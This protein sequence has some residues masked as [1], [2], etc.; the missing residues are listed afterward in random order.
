M[1][2]FN[3][4]LVQSLGT[5]NLPE[6]AIVIDSSDRQVTLARRDGGVSIK[7]EVQSR[8][9]QADGVAFITTERLIFCSKRPYRKQHGMTFQGFEIPLRLV[10]GVTCRQ[11]SSVSTKSISGMVHSGVAFPAQG[12]LQ[13]AGFPSGPYVS[14]IQTSWHLYF[15][16]GGVGTF[17]QVYQKVIRQLLTCPAAAATIGRRLNEEEWASSQAR[18]ILGGVSLDR[19]DTT[20]LFKSAK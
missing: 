5:R 17:Y 8:V 2:T 9:F 3:S 10:S 11:S 4:P 18:V 6:H 1:A 15:R 13:G 16:R 14:T 12:H 20:T 19:T 7:V